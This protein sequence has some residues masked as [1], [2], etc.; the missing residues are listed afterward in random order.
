MATTTYDRDRAI[1]PLRPDPSALRENALRSV[2]RAVLFAFKTAG[3][4]HVEPHPWQHD[5]AVDLALRAATAPTRL[6]DAAGLTQLKLHFLPSL[7]PAS[8]AARVIDLSFKFAFDGAASI[9]VPSL[10]LPVAGWIGEGSGISVSQGSSTANSS[11]VPS[12]L[13]AIIPI[14]YEMTIAADAEAIMQQV[15][16]ETAAAAL[17]A[18]F[19]NTNAAVANVSPAGILNAVTP[20]GAASAGVGAMATDLGNMIAAVGPFSGSSEPVIIAAPKQAFAIKSALIDPPPV[21][22]SNVLATSPVGPGAVIAIVPQ[23][24]ASANGAPRIERSTETTLHMSSPASDL[25]ASPST[26]AAPQRSLFQTD[27]VAVKYVQELSW[28]KRGA[29]GVAWIQG[30]NWP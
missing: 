5:R 10:S 25:V 11:M 14:T 8:A 18:A 7:I 26:V 28:T 23:A 21:Y 29:A 27:S 15:L 20:I 30:C 3:N 1:V 24:I 4:K 17:D 12:K 6:A 2:A 13:G 22:A 16:L 9:S 19:F